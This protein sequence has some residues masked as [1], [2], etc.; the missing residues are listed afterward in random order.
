MNACSHQ[1]SVLGMYSLAP[2]SHVTIRCGL[3]EKQNGINEVFLFL[4][5]DLRTIKGLITCVNTFSHQVSVLGMYPL[6]PSSHMT[7]RCGLQEKQNGI[8]EVFL[9]LPPDLRTMLFSA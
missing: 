1:A 3:L 5:P 9:F 7:I 8:N 6:P 4:P 2:S